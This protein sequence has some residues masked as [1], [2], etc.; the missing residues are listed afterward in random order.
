MEQWVVDPAI[1][2]PYYPTINQNQDP[3]DDIWFTAEFG[4]SYR[5]TLTFCQGET[6]EDGEIQIIFFGLPGIGYDA[7]L[8]AMETDLAVLMTQL[9]PSGKLVLTGRSAPFEY[10]GGSAE[11]E[12]AASVFIEYQYFQ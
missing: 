7:V 4:A 10:S 12:Y 9:D 3:R 11:K 6:M 8:T 2:T 5:E 1:Q